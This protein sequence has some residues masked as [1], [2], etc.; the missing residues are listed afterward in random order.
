MKTKSLKIKVHGRVQ[1]VG[2]RYSTVQAA[3]KIG[4]NGWV[5]NEW[6]GT[7]LIYCEG[8]SRSVDTFV[9]WCRKGPTLSHVVSLD[10]TDVPFQGLY[11]S[12]KIEY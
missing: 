7:V 9:A 1:G 4:V 10:I 11:D 6:D 2:F 3:V 5:R 8:N 12:F